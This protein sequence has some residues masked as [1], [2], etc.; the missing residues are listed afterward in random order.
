MHFGFDFVRGV[1]DSRQ[2]VIRRSHPQTGYQLRPALM[3]IGRT[4]AEFRAQPIQVCVRAVGG[5]MARAAS[6]GDLVGL[7]VILV[8]PHVVAES[9]RKGIE[10][11]LF[12]AVRKN[13]IAQCGFDLFVGIHGLDYG[14]QLNSLRGVGSRN[15]LVRAE[16]AIGNSVVMI[17]HLDLLVNRLAIFR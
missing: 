9:P 11:D 7:L 15:V 13:G 5:P 1:G 10:G 8:R 12:Q 4:A 6:A 17:Q 2:S 14:A 3:H 16:H